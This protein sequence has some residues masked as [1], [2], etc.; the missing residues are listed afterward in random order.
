MRRSPLVFVLAMMGLLVLLL[1]PT[2][3]DHVL[4][5][6]PTPTSLFGVTETVQ[7]LASTSGAIEAQPLACQDVGS[8]AEESSLAMIGMMAVMDPRAEAMAFESIIG[9]GAIPAVTIPAKNTKSEATIEVPTSV[10]GE[11]T[12]ALASADVGLG[13]VD[14]DVVLAY[15]V[16]ALLGSLG[17]VDVLVAIRGPATTTID[18]QAQINHALAADQDQGW[19]ALDEIVALAAIDINSAKPAVA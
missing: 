7:T 2:V 6:A 4:A 8:V 14:S 12:T 16:D 1:A 11:V 17:Y 5:T 19:A 15:D 18:A 10:A 9:D 3:T 13:A